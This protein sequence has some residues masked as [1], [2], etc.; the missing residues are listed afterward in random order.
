MWWRKKNGKM[1]TT[2]EH[3]QI[4]AQ[5][6][7][8]SLGN[9]LVQF[10]LIEPEHLDRALQ[11]QRDNPDLMLGETLV[12][13]GQIDHE[14]LS[15]TMAQQKILRA[16]CQERQKVIMHKLETVAA[17]TATVGSAFDEIQ[18]ISETLKTRMK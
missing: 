2:L 18:K 13:M 8:T 6:D 14:V 10:R 9:L 17:Q 11:F 12:R 16:S 15:V 1:K 4:L 5:Q 7:S 3:R